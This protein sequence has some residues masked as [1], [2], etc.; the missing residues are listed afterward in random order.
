MTDNWN[1]LGHE[2]AV[3][4]LRQHVTRGNMR[5][6]YLFSGAPG[7]GRR[8]LALRLAQA[9]NCTQ[10]I[11][12]GIP[13][14]TCRDCKQ[15]EAMQHPD[16]N[17]IQAK[18]DDGLPKENGTLKVEQVREVRRALS[19]KPYQS[20]YRV[21]V[22][23]RFQEANDN[24]ANALLKTLEEAP[25]HAILILTA[26]TPE[27]LLPTIISRCE[28][29]RLRPLPV[30]AIEADLIERGVDAERARLLAHIS[31]GRPGYAR[32]LIDDATILEARE[33]RLNDMQTLLPASRV[34][35]FAYA[36]KLSKDKDAMRQTILTWLSY[37]RDVMLRVA[38]AETPLTNIDL[39][40][41]IEFLA[42]RL[43][44]P[45]ARRVVSELES[46][47]AKMDGNVNSRLLAEVLL[48]DL[49][50]A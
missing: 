4:M 28:I 9:L 12:A 38:Q 44:L 40:M 41:E 37:W 15:I 1:I 14:L 31:G 23:L 10:P 35:K 27:Q 22:F 33:E 13:C 36:E 24:A 45:A 39:N 30:G 32:R 20:K 26:D 11:G 49:P 18:D 17:I 47:L 2:W 21:A 46:T 16:L 34:E 5:H 7:L 25:A 8:T 50:K 48:L 43:D 6:A 19:L 3:D 42:G 29:L